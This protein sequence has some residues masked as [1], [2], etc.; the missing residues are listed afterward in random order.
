MVAVLGGGSSSSGV[1]GQ[2][3][4]VS[5]PSASELCYDGW[6]TL[7]PWL[8][9]PQSL[10]GVCEPQAS[11]QAPGA[12]TEPQSGGCLGPGALGQGA[13]DTGVCPGTLGRFSGAS[14]VSGT[15][16]SVG[17]GR[18]RPQEHGGALGLRGSLL[19][20]TGVTEMGPVPAPR[21]T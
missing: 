2:L 15:S 20:P 13:G 3:A 1:W 17:A 6:D 7:R 19:P 11:S 5:P 16:S 21:S 18:C 8:L 14:W 9:S 4:Q 10:E 12:P